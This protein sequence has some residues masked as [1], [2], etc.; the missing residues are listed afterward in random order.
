MKKLG[1][2]VVVL[3]VVLLVAP[4]GIGKIAEKRLNAG[5]DKA[6]EQVPPR[7]TASLILM[8]AAS[9]TPRLSSAVSP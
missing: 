6:M 7:R 2:I 8:T 4:F 5:I 1:I 9:A 3:A